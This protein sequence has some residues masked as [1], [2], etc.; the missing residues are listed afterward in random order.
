MPVEELTAVSGELEL[1]GTL[2]TPPGDVM[3]PTVIALHGASNGLRHAPL[4]QHLQALLPAHGIAVLTYDRRGEGASSG[5]AELATFEDKAADAAAWIDR[6]R[7]HPQLDPDRLGLWGHS[8]GGWIAPMAASQRPGS[9]AA[10]ICVSPSAVTPSVQM[11]Y[12]Y[13]HQIR[14]RGFSEEDARRG[15][16]LR[17]LVDAYWRNDGVSKDEAV[18]AMEAAKSEP[19]YSIAPPPDP[20]SAAAETWREEMDLDI[21]PVLA[22]L[23]MPILV[24]FGET[25]R[26]VP[27][28]ASADVWRRAVAEDADLT[29]VTVAGA[30]HS[31]SLAD[32]PLDLAEAGP[33]APAY[34]QALVDWLAA[35]L[36]VAAA[37][38]AA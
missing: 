8:Q 36:V 32:D 2:V 14:E 19:W 35:R 24:V 38:D 29:V 9:V 20:R 3:H 12:A 13:E 7:E 16:E 18:A 1:H 37:H 25:D 5:D 28:E 17:R 31:P 34:E 4:Y 23:T 22:Q 11:T 26:W 6:L 21:A 33:I 10:M 15:A 27:I 30:G